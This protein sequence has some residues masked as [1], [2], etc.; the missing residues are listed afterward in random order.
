MLKVIRDNIRFPDSSLGDMRS[1][2]AAC[3][4]AL[5]RLDE[6]FA[7]FGRDTMLDAIKQIFAETEQRCRTVVSTIPDGVYEASA[8]YDVPQRRPQA[9]DPCP[10][11]RRPRRT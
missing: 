4:L 8:I 7:K 1:Q 11:H 5:R 3:R 9:A 6:L 2:I 10:R